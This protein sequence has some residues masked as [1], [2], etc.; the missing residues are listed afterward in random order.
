MFSIS[1]P[2]GA[3]W[4]E[5]LE[6]L[7]RFKEFVFGEHSIPLPK[8]LID[9]EVSRKEY[10]RDH[11]TMREL[12]GV[13]LFQNSLSEFLSQ[14]NIE[15]SLLAVGSS[16]FPKK[17]MTIRGITCSDIDL[18]VVAKNPSDLASCDVWGKEGG[19]PSRMHGR[20]YISCRLAET[21]DKYLLLQGMPDLTSLAP[22][23]GQ[24]YI[25]YGKLNTHLPL[26]GDRPI[27]L[28]LEYYHP[29]HFKV[30]EGATEEERLLVTEPTAERK[31]VEERR[32]NYPF[33]LLK[34]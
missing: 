18:L 28:V 20:R 12:S 5:S 27:H 33:C 8:C 4:Q 19:K 1:P 23:P 13:A 3:C 10:F 21:I 17:L 22:V 9:L 32:K 30:K 15:F 6:N 34:E 31:I 26:D 7:L 2:R 16:T 29:S 25:P 24:V 14:E 11:L